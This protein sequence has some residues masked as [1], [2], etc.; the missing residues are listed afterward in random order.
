MAGLCL[1]SNKLW[2]TVVRLV[3]AIVPVLCGRGVGASAWQL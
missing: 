1:W 3:G 2:Y